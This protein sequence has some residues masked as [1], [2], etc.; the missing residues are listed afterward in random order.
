[1]KYVIVVFQA[2]VAALFIMTMLTE[3]LTAVAQV[4]GGLIVAGSLVTAAYT[5]KGITS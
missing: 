2:L 4:L 5:A 3:E 1:M